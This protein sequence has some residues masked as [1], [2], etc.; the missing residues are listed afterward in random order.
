MVDG[1]DSGDVVVIFGEFYYYLEGGVKKKM[2]FKYSLVV[3]LFWCFVVV[4]R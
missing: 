1:R 3:W 2:R 4:F